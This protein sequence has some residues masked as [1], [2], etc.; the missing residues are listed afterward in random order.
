MKIEEAAKQLVATRSALLA[1]P[2]GSPLFREKLND[3]SNAEAALVKA[4]RK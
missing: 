1:L 2:M 4:V 3:L